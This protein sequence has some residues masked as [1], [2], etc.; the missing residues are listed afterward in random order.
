MTHEIADRDQHLV[1]NID[2]VTTISSTVSKMDNPL[3]LGQELTK[4]NAISRNR[5][6]RHVQR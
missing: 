5:N 6:K 1:G 4:M 2:S 3:L